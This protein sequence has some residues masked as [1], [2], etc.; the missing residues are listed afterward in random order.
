MQV[1]LWWKT[2]CIAARSKS[3]QL[4][5][6]TAR[7]LIKTNQVYAY[8]LHGSVF[9]DNWC[10]V[11]SIEWQERR[12]PKG[13]QQKNHS[14]Q[15]DSIISAELKVTVKHVKRDPCGILDPNLSAQKKAN[16]P[17]DIQFSTTFSTWYTDRQQLISF[18]W[19]RNPLKRGHTTK[20]KI[21]GT[22]DA[23]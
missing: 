3:L 16:V 15:V 6:S 22:Q 11:C 17:N 21:F 10:C 1:Y 14:P 4:T 9:K 12:L 5:W 19:R 2:S 20:M 18:Y 23:L 7:I 13:C 8:Y